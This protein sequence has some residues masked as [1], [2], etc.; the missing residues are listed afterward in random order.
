M[1]LP[2]IAHGHQQGKVTVTR[3]SVEQPKRFRV[4]IEVG[5]RKRSRTLASAEKELVSLKL[6]SA[7][8]FTCKP[9][10]LCSP[11]SLSPSLPYLTFSHRAPPSFRSPLD[12][13]QLPCLSR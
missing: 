11:V 1:V 9:V 7:R 8:S 10:A 12:P 5:D 4:I 6:D 13:I 3:P 2:S